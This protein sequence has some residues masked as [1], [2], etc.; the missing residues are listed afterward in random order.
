MPRAPFICSVLGA[1]P[2]VAVP[3]RE[4]VPFF[5]GSAGPP[6][7]N[8]SEVFVLGIAADPLPFATC[9]LALLGWMGEER[10]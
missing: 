3:S 6:Y 8:D 4:F 5:P 7:M 10:P 1:V 9:P 2:P